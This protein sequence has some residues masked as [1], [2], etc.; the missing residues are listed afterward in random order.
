MLQVIRNFS[1]EFTTVALELMAAK[2]RPP[3]LIAVR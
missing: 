2:V 1:Q 3:A